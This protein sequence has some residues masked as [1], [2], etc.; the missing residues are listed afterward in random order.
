M[1]APK[2]AWTKAAAWPSAKGAEMWQ[3]AG[4]MHGRPQRQHEKSLSVSAVHGMALGK[5]R[6]CSE[7]QAEKEAHQ[8]QPHGSCLGL[9]LKREEIAA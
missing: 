9:K 4:G 8:R 2:S 3:L 6:R 7:K 1:D 5:Q